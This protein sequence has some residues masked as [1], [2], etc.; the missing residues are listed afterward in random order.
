MTS[1]PTLSGYHQVL[2][3]LLSY[4]RRQQN[5]KTKTTL[6]S[7]MVQAA[8]RWELPFQLVLWDSCSSRRQLIEQVKQLDKDWIEGCSKDRKVSYQGQWPPTPGDLYQDHPRC[9]LS[10]G[11][12]Q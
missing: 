7:E 2:V 12:N 11:Q 8:V 9:R 1:A 3:E 10:A 5:F 6:A 4:R